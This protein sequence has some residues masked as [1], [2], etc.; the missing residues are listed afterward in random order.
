MKQQIFEIY[1]ITL[2]ATSLECTSIINNSTSDS[3][4]YMHT[5]TYMLYNANLYYAD[6]QFC[7]C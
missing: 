6:K 2:Q 7:M 1:V 4:L 5:L 3:I